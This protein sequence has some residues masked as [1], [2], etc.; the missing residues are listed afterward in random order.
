MMACGTPYFPWRFRRRNPNTKCGAYV[1]AKRVA[2]DWN[3]SKGW[4]PDLE[5]RNCQ[6]SKEIWKVEAPKRNT[7]GNGFNPWH[8]VRVVRF[9]SK[10]ARRLLDEHF[11]FR[12]QI[13][14][15]K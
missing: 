4:R 6:L 3:R 7:K 8:L 10:W 13:G 2:L 11:T 1:A 12:E 14:R 15:L 5:A 9:C